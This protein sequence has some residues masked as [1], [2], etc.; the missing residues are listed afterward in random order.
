[1]SAS[2]NLRKRASIAIIRKNEYSKKLYRDNE[3]GLD[4]ITKEKKS[5]YIKKKIRQRV[6]RYCYKYNKKT[7]RSKTNKKTGIYKTE[8]ADIYLRCRY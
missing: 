7:G 6:Q 8:S 5:N 3:I 1:M 4:I 2:G